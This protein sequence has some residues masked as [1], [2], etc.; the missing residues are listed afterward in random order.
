M[1]VF[2]DQAGMSAFYFPDQMRKKTSIVG[3]ILKWDN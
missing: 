3:R 1:R 2:S